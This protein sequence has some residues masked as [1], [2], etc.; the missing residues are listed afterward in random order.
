MKNLIVIRHAKSSW[1]DPALADF[2]R[3]LNKRGKRDAPLMGG[4]LKSRG[5]IPD[6]VV[7]SPAKRARKTAKLIAGEIGYDTEAIDLKENLY[8]AEMPVLIELI[9]GLDDAWNR[10]YL[11]GHNPGLIDLVGRLAGETIT[12]LPTCGVASIEFEVDS[13]THLMAG[14]GRLAFFDYP[15][16]HL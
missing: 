10:V 14:A 7:S 6:R 15:N 16:Q 8:L 4:I 12:H 9:R 5:L 3:P 1:G 2:D 13:W 11:I